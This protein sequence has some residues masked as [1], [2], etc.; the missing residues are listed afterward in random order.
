MERSASEQYLDGVAKWKDER[1]EVEG[2]RLGRNT[3]LVSSFD[4]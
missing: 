4:R 3:T 2:C 1:E